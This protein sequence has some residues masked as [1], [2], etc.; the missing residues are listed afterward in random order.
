[1]NLVFD[2]TFFK[3]TKGLLVFRAN[4]RNIYWKYIK[5]ETITNIS[6]AFDTV[7]A[8]CKYGY[9]SFTIDG[10]RGVLRFLQRRYSDVPIQ[11]CQFHQC[12]IIR[13]YNT[14]N[15]RTECGKALKHLMNQLTDIL[16]EKEFETK[17]DILKVLYEDF[18]KERNDNNQFKHKRLRSAFRSLNVNKSYLFTCRKYPHLNIPNTTNTC[19]G[20]FS[21]WKNKIKLHR[22]LAEHRKMKMI[23]YLLE[24][25]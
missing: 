3:R 16:F 20:S 2:G 18:L 23:N 13:R 21:H 19:E 9:K 15:P 14:N 7:D 4:Q 10:R 25:S 12:M 11:F 8:I 5:S 17:F 6:I 22:G 1:M 24:N